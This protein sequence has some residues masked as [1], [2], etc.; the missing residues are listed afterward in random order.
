M[1]PIQKKTYT[2]DLETNTRFWKNHPSEDNLNLHFYVIYWC[3][4]Y[5]N[6]F[7]DNT[8]LL[9]KVSMNKK[10]GNNLN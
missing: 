3:F 10:T 6:Q 4:C 9:L 8:E 5:Q 7:V 1:F 2:L